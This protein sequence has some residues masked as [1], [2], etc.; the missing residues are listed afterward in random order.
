[1]IQGKWAEV[2]TKLSKTSVND[3]IK[4]PFKWHLCIF[5][6]HFQIVENCTTKKVF[7][8]H[9]FH[10][11][12]SSSVFGVFNGLF[13]PTSR[14][15]ISKIFSD[16]E[17]LGKSNG[18]KWSQIWTFLFENCRKSRHK[19]SFF[20]SN[21]FTF[22]RS[23]SVFYFNSSP[24]WA[25]PPPAPPASHGRSP[26]SRGSS[27]SSAHIFYVSPKLSLCWWNMFIIYCAQLSLLGESCNPP[28]LRACVQ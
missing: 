8:L 28:K 12:L 10:F 1:M 25:P 7:F 6:L 22:F 16:S 9:F 27:F 4:M 21:F 19:K 2:W 17:S 14:S 24:L 18:K 5:K 26:P 20:S 3:T 15:R 23:S 13:A 11:F